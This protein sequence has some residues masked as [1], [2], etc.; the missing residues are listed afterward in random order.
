MRS[1]TS[2]SRGRIHPAPFVSLPSYCS[3]I[4]PYGQMTHG[5]VAAPERSESSNTIQR[6]LRRKTNQHVRIVLCD[7]FQCG[8][9]LR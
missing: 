6:D 1:I 3:S 7:P 9:S 2:Q 5:Q 4:C 8:N